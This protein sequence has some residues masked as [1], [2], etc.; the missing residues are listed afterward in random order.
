MHNDTGVELKN[1]GGS[2]EV[3]DALTDILRHGAHQLLTQAI[4]TEVTEFLTR[5]R[6]AR[7]EVGLLLPPPH[8]T[9]GSRKAS[10]IVRYTTMDQADLK[11]WNAP[12]PRSTA[13]A[14]W[15]SLR[16]VIRNTLCGGKRWSHCLTLHLAH[17]VATSHGM[18]PM[19]FD[20]SPLMIS[21]N[22]PSEPTFPSP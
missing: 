3:Q 16:M 4:E 1:P 21:K 7:D 8:L 19:Q 9:Q 6:D 5:Y 20:R 10:D 12:T 15:S 22:T 11:K 2:G 13:A 18:V 14:S 17:P